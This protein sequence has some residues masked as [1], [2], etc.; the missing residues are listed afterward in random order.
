MGHGVAPDPLPSHPGVRWIDGHLDLAYLALCGRDLRVACPDPAVG[1][2]SL[3]ALR[4]AGVGLVLATVFTEP[5]VTDRSQPF[6]Y[7]SSD[8]LDD[9]EQAGRRQLEV[10]HRLDAQGEIGIVRSRGDLD[11]Q[12]T[13]PGP[14]AVLLMEGADP[15]RCPDDAGQWFA[16]G[17]RVVGLSWAA[18]TRYAGGNGNPGPLTPLGIELV[19]ALD[20][21]GIVHDASHLADE[22]FEGLAANAR[23]AIVATHSNCRALAGDSQRHLRD[24]QIA[25]IGK[26]GGIVGLNLFAKFLAPGGRATISDCVAHLERVC[27]IMGHRRGIGLG[28]DMDG[29]FDPTELPAGLDHPRKL[30]ALAE[31]LHDAGWPD[32]DIEGFR[33]ANWRRFLQRALS[34]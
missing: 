4:E 10:Y 6:G 20:D 32:Q 28:S 18:G 1:C 14:R 21:L 13:G 7:G 26:R 23:G 19:R 29:G 15:I 22:A 34:A 33:H 25:E 2:I 5:G 17:V 11:V 31:A 16:R 8:D 30:E 24:E 9:A 3:P 27:G 12:A